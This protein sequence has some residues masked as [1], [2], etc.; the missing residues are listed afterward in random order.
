M[1]QGARDGAKRLRPF[2]RVSNRLCN[3]HS[4]GRRTI[5]IW[6]PSRRELI[7]AAPSLVGAAALARPLHA[8]AGRNLRL[9]VLGDW[10]RDGD[11]YQKH[12]ATLMDYEARQS[13]CDLIV[14]TGDNFYYFGVS[15]SRDAK[16]RTSYESIYSPELRR[17]PWFPVAG[18]HDWGGSIW[19]QL[20]RTG[21]AGWNMPWLWYDIPGSRFGRPDVH[22]FFV[23]TTVWKG[24]E[25]KLFRLCGQAIRHEDTAKQKTWLAEALRSSC[26]PTKLVFGHHPIYWT[27]ADGGGRAMRDLDALLT[28]ARVTAYVCGHKHSLFHIRNAGLDYICS[29]GGSE[30]RDKDSRGRFD[31]DTAS[32]SRFIG[33]AGFA[34][35]EVGADAVTYSFVDRN[36]RATPPEPI[37]S[38]GNHALGCSGPLAVDP[39]VERERAR[40][41]AKTYLPCTFLT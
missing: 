26:A 33:R 41:R 36:G 35:L 14:T 8:A 4:G 20:D 16:W 25:N 32:L 11:H 15:S 37:K 27:N 30:E 6:Q 2:A 39:A 24:K 5:A 9:F 12:V 17:T 13:G 1:A 7:T 22:L 23:D 19:A 18:N 10:G 29:G 3:G 38:R 21:N 40:A 34:I 31:I 28:E